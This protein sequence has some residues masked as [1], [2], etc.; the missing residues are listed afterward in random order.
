[1]N[2]MLRMCTERG[3]DR[4][5]GGGGGGV[6]CGV[7]ALTTILKSVWQCWRKGPILQKQITDYPKTNYNFL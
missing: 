7:E 3:R 4:D 2:V 1:M 5:D 6:E